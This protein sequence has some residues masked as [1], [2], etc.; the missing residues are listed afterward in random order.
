MVPEVASSRLVTHPKPENE[1]TGGS[2]GRTPSAQV[3]LQWTRVTGSNPV[4]GTLRVFRLTT[5]LKPQGNADEI[6]DEAK[7]CV[8]PKVG[9]AFQASMGRSPALPVKQ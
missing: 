2:L 9:G 1:P 6:G 5:G 8:P 4:S 7:S 3:H